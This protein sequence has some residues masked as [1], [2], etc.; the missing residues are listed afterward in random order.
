MGLSI[1]IFQMNFSLHKQIY[2]IGTKTFI[3]VNQLR[4]ET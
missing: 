4:I 2:D 3:V 1:L